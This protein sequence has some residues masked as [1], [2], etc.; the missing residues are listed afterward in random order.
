ML[1]FL[2]EFGFSEVGEWFLNDDGLDFQLGAFDN[3]LG[4]LYAFVAGDSVKYIGKSVRSL[5]QRLLGYKN[6]GPSQKTNRANHGKIIQ[7]LA[8]GSSVKI[9]A[10]KSDEILFYKGVPIDLVAGLEPTLIDKCQPPWNSLGI[11]TK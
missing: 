8:S 4:V 5:K 7:A 9:F 1:D 6:P 3:E 11:S 2:I 10:F